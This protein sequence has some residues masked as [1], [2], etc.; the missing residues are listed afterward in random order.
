MFKTIVSSVLLFAV[1]APVSA[2]NQD[3]DREAKQILTSS[4]WC[5]FSYNSVTGTSNSSRVVFH[6]NGI[7]TINSG[8]E[9]YSKGYAG[10]YA[11]QSQGGNRMK[12]KLENLRMYIDQG[13]GNGFVDIG[14][15]ATTNSNGYP[16]LHAGGKEYSMCK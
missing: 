14:L 9:T 11:G 6:T 12:W 13:D 7:M 8:S 3:A 2:G 15:E 4:A 5:S 16:I 10:T 1:A